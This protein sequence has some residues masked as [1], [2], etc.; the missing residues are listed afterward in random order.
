MSSSHERSTC[1]RFQFRCCKVPDSATMCLAALHHFLIQSNFIG[2][3][4]RLHLTPNDAVW[5][6][7]ERSFSTTLVSVMVPAWKRAGAGEWGSDSSICERNIHCH[8]RPLMMY[9]CSPLPLLPF[10]FLSYLLPPLSSTS[11]PPPTSKKNL[12][13]LTIKFILI[14]LLENSSN[15]K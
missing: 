7:E 15:T 10:F 6:A 3:Q 12:A 9:S 2:G 4:I 5:E 13:C 11:R 8:R 1:E 14:F